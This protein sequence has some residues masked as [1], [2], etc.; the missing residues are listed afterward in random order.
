MSKFSFIKKSL[1][2]SRVTDLLF[3][4]EGERWGIEREMDGK[5]WDGWIRE[6]RGAKRDGWI[7]KRWKGGNER[8]ECLR[9]RRVLREGVGRQRGRWDAKREMDR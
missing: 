9:E 2:L 7:A 1:N 5:G 8:D 6:R 3:G 4:R